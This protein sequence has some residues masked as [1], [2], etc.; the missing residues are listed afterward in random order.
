MFTWQDPESK[1]VL[2]QGNFVQDPKSQICWEE[3][4]E[5]AVND[6]VANFNMGMVATIEVLRQCGIEPGDLQRNIALT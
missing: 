3:T 5:V 1:L 4:F 2:Q 6:A